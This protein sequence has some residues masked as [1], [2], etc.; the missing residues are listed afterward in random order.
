[1][2]RD[3]YM[4]SECGGEWWYHYTAINTRHNGY[5]I[6]ARWSDL[7]Q[8]RRERPNH[9]DAPYF[10][11]WEGHW[12]DGKQTKYLPA[13]ARCQPYR[14]AHAEPRDV[15]GDLTTRPHQSGRRRATAQC[16]DRARRRHS[17][18]ANG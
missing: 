5:G 3:R 18:R 4:Y 6:M 1:M 14:V 12:A 16:G 2:I 10:T 9:A 7:A 13:I 8:L 17:H 15:R 11:T